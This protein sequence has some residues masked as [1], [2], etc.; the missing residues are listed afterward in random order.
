MS[1]DTAATTTEVRQPL[2][3][4]LVWHFM[5]EGCNAAEIAAHGHIPEFVA[6][7]WMA[8]A[9]LVF[10]GQRVQRLQESVS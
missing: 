4:A 1:T 3:D 8:H 10:S 9:A 7:A 6:Q 2:S 5:S